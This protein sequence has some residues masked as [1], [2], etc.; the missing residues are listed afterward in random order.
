MIRTAS[1]KLSA[2]GLR[3]VGPACPQF[4]W[5]SSIKW[6]ELNR[7]GFLMKGMGDLSCDGSVMLFDDVFDV[8]QASGLLLADLNEE[9]GIALFDGLKVRSAPG[10]NLTLSF[11]A[12]TKYRD[13]LSTFLV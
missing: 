10:G 2:I 3:G 7:N 1:K 8:V 9:I 12:Q 13:L 11:S 4:E 6:I 5:D